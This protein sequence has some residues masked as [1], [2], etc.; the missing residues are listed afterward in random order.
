MLI[1]YGLYLSLGSIS[2]AACPKS[3][4]PVKEVSLQ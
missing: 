1:L 4:W 2:R 3:A